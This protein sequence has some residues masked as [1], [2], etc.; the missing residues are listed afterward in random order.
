VSDPAAEIN[1]FLDAV[2]IR[3]DAFGVC[4]IGRHSALSCAPFDAVVVHF[5]LSGEGFLECE[6]GRFPLA[7]GMVA[8]IPRGL[9]KRLS[10]VGPIEHSMDAQ[11]DCSYS[12]E[13]VKFCPSP[14]QADL[15]LGCAKLSSRIAGELPLFDQAKRPI[16]EQSRDPLLTS[17]FSTM[18]DELR[19]PRLGTAAFVGALMKQVLIVMLR[20]QP[21]DVSSILLMSG[22]RLAGLVAAILDRPEENYTVESLAAQVGMSRSCFIQQFTAAY[23]CSPKA[24]V[25][26]ARL[27]AAARMLKSSSLP[28]KSVAASVGFASRSHFSRAFHAKFGRDPSTFRRSQAAK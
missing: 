11:P 6:H 25:Q 5:V 28:V 2:D 27:A 18:F 9:S 26:T 10:G 16:F 8:V 14:G 12:E 1:G 22:K 15:I 4:E 20:S 13:L 19:N 24:F 23:D 3:V 21:D 7:E 17:L